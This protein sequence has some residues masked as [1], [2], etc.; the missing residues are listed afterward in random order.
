[1]FLVDGSGSIGDES[2]NVMKQFLRSFVSGLTVASDKVR[3]GLAQFT[4]NAYQEF[5]LNDHDNVQ[6][7]LD[8]IGRLQY[9]QGGTYLGKGLSFLQTNYFT[10]AGGS[11][12]KVPKIAIVIT[13]G[14][15]SDD[16]AVPARDLRGMG[17]LV[18]A[19][20]VGQYDEAQLRSVANKP[21]DRFLVGIN[22][23]QEL[24]NIMDDMQRTVCTSVT[25]EAEGKTIELLKY[26][27]LLWHV[28]VFV[29]TG[30]YDY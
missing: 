28:P 9:R 15:S 7:V 3:V 25:I 6:A 16:V 27:C 12:D 1:M 23:Y 4:D 17:V 29:V 10:P 11:R 21:A 8:Q 24:Q 18:Y 19:I 13:D 30:Q 22:N 14:Q 2:F 20:G 26:H 5:L